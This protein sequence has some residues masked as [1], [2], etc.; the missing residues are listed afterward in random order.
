MSF[1]EKKKE[2]EQIL[3][4]LEKEEISLDESI[5]LFDKAS[6]LAKECSEALSNN[7]GKVTEI[8]R[9]MDSLVEK[10]FEG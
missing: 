6:K 10:D 1:E 4:K 2:L 9:E 3:N 5:K 8:K 7:E